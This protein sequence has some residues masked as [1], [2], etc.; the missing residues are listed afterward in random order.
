MDPKSKDTETQRKNGISKMKA[1]LL[2]MFLQAR[3]PRVASNHHKLEEKHKRD[4]PSESPEGTNTATP[5][6]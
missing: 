5:G 4:F 6:F 1:E 3:V 2:G